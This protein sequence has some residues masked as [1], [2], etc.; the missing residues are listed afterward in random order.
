MQQKAADKAMAK[1]ANC[2]TVETEI[3]FSLIVARAYKEVISKK[4]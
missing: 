4:I 2:K 3:F 1:T